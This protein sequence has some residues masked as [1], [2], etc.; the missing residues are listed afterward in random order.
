MSSVLFHIGEKQTIEIRDPM[1]IIYESILNKRH[2]LALKSRLPI[3][4]KLKRITLRPDFY[5][6]LMMFLTSNHQAITVEL[7]HGSLF[8]AYVKI[9]PK[10][11]HLFELQF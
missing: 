6:N 9:D 1:Q 2:D 7:L 4:P 8:N 11:P 5:H 10:L 3:S